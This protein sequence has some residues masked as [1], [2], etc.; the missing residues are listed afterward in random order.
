MHTLGH[1]AAG[2]RACFAAGPHREDSLL[3]GEV[4]PVIPVPTQLDL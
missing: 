3:L 1:S 2:N 4:I